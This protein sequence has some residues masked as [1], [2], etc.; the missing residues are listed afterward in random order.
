MPGG[1]Q[2][3]GSLGLAL[4]YATAAVQLNVHSSLM[5]S[6]P[7]TLLQTLLQNLG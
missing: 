6:N 4:G 7:E 3:A 1:Q 5:P 2:V